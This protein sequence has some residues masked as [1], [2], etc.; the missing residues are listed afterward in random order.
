[1]Q[2]TCICKTKSC[3]GGY[4][5]RSTCTWWMMSNANMCMVE[6]CWA[7]K[8]SLND[9]QCIHVSSQYVRESQVVVK[10]MVDVSNFLVGSL[11]FY[12]VQPLKT[13]SQ[14]TKLNSCTMY[15][16]VCLQSSTAN[17]CLYCNSI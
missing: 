5:H 8:H 13:E 1:M 11:V 16:L 4:G 6:L 2:T 12:L 7:K 14:R 9:L 3:S 17:I 10:N 15:A